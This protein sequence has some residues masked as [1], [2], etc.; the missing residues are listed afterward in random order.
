MTAMFYCANPQVCGVKRHHHGTECKAQMSKVNGRGSL[1]KATS[2]VGKR[3]TALTEDELEDHQI[4][5]GL[6][7]TDLHLELV[8]ASV[9]DANNHLDTVLRN[10]AK[11]AADSYIY[12]V[13]QTDGESYLADR[14]GRVLRADPLGD[15]IRCF[16]DEGG[17]FDIRHNM[18]VEEINRK[19]RRAFDGNDTGVMNVGYGLD[20]DVAPPD[21]IWKE[22]RYPDG[23][24]EDDEDGPDFRLKNELEDRGYQFFKADRVGNWT[25]RDR[26][27]NMAQRSQDM[28]WG[29]SHE[30]SDRRAASD[31]EV[32]LKRGD[33]YSVDGH[34]HMRVDM[35][36][37]GY[38]VLSP[39]PLMK[40]NEVGERVI[41][42]PGFDLDEFDDVYEDMW[43]KHEALS[44]KGVEVP[45]DF[46][47]PVPR[48]VALSNIKGR[49]PN[50]S[51]GNGFSTPDALDKIEEKTGYVYAEDGDG[52]GCFVKS[53]DGEFD[54]VPCQINRYG[55]AV[56]VGPEIRPGYGDH[57]LMQIADQQRP[58]E[59]KSWRAFNVP[60]NQTGRFNA[61]MKKMKKHNELAGIEW[62]KHYPSLG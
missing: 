20:S 58:E 17:F 4:R 46:S 6:E 27:G 19:F 55:Q 52:N 41:F 14:S 60:L 31:S 62:G 56:P 33:P 29:K 59:M 43:S 10:E 16:D 48:R 38:A 12:A 22:K 40:E 51:Y 24:P 21:H 45:E 39:T 61:T 57:D 15:G 30:E 35:F 3:S 25:R 1:P 44:V 50:A 53:G 32:F 23:F 28:Y 36:S 47:G 42:E 49:F 26:L 34:K 18:P 9:P 5:F 2:T 8:E 7:K 13:S 37:G 11:T 54:L